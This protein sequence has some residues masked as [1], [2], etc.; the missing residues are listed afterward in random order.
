MALTLPGAR[1][2]HEGQMEGRRVRL[3]VFLAQ[4][5]EELADPDLPVFYRVLLDALSKG[6]F[7]SGTRRL[8]DRSGWPDNESYLN[9]VAWCWQNGNSR[10]LIV[11]N[12]S[13]TAS[14]CLVRIPWDDL[15]SKTWR[16]KDVFSAAEYERDGDQICGPGLYVDLPAWGFHLLEWLQEC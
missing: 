12:L 1:L 16:L 6:D 14:Q 4:R 3:P 10:C 2:I 7:L 8:C 11:V 15:K 9:L 5:P 13:E